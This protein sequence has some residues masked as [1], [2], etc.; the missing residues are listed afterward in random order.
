MQEIRKI[1]RAN[2]SSFALQTDDSEFIEPQS[3]KAGVQK[4]TSQQKQQALMNKPPSC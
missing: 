4:L 1:L 3:A 2:L